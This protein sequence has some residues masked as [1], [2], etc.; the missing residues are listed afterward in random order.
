MTVSD[1][2]I[3][4]LITSLGSAIIFMYHK[5]GA[6]HADLV[7]RA[8]AC[9]AEKQRLWVAMAELKGDSELLARCPAPRCPLREGP[10]KETTRIQ[11]RSI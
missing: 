6:D 3:Y 9:E 1:A 4:T 7:K 10:R 5:Q 8:D 11:P 2:I